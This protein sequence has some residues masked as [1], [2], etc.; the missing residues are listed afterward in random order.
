MH[1]LTLYSSDL[2]LVKFVTNHNAKLHYQGNN[3]RNKVMLVFDRVKNNPN[4]IWCDVCICEL[5]TVE[6]LNS[7]KQS[8]K[9]YKKALAQ[10]EISKVKQ[11]YLAKINGGGENSAA[12]CIVNDKPLKEKENAFADQN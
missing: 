3:H 6:M 12:D 2:C 5:N 8:E 4:I 7:H 9:H 11:E 1:L 10:E